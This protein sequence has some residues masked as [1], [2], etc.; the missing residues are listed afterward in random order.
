MNTPAHQ[1]LQLLIFG[2]TYLYKGGEK[3]VEIIKRDPIS[4]DIKDTIESE[5][6]AIQIHHI[7]AINVITDVLKSIIEGMDTPVE[8]IITPVTTPND[9]PTPDTER[10][11]LKTFLRFP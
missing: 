3:T 7:P 2:V 5:L 11:D 10:V 4:I 1:H 6:K 9:S 8:Y